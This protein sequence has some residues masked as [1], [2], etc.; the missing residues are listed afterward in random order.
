MRLDDVL[1]ALFRRWRMILGCT[2]VGFA[3]AAAV[4][5]LREPLYESRAKLLVR[6]VLSRDT[7]DSYQTH[8]APGGSDRRR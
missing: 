6:Y 2:V 5:V 4:M 1:R 3:A 8:S 7:V